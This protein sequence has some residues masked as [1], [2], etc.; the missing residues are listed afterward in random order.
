MTAGNDAIVAKDATGVGDSEFP[1]NGPLVFLGTQSPG[2]NAALE[3]V[4]V[5]D[6]RASEALS[7]HQT[8][9]HLGNV[10]SARVLGR[11]VHLESSPESLC[12]HFTQRRLQ[13]I[14]RVRAEIVHDQM[15]LAGSWIASRNPLQCPRE[16]PPGAVGRAVRQSAPGQRFDDAEDVRRPLAHI[17]VVATACSPW[18]HGHI[19]PRWVQ[20]LHRPLVQAHHRLPRAV[21]S[22]IELKDVFH[23]GHEL[24]VVFGNAP[25]FFPARA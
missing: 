11:V 3:G 17:F 23:A 16:R 4:Q 20:Q 14:Q 5:A 8:G 18:P 24:S 12:F 21:R 19:G 25:H 22:R 1:A 2:S 9:L 10:E 15:D 7:R 6:P 13:R